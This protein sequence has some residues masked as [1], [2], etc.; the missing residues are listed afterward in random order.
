MR[1]S[2]FM[3]AIAGMS[4]FCNFAAAQDN[5][6]PIRLVVGFAP[7]GALDTVARAVADRLRITLKQPVIVDNKPG[8]SQRLALSEVKRAKP[9]G[10]TL[11]LANS[12]PFIIFPHVYTKLEF[13]P[14]KDFTPVAG[15]ANLPLCIAVGP[16]VPEGNLK[17]V[18]NWAKAHPKEASFATSGAGQMGHF[19]GLMLGSSSGTPFTHVAYKGGVPALQ[20]LIGGQLPMMIDT[21]LEPMEMAKVARVK[22]IATSGEKRLEVLPAVPTIRESGFNLSA[23][24][25][26]GIYG[27]AGIPKDKLQRLNAGLREALASPELKSRIQQLA[28]TPTHLPP[29]ELARWLAEGRAMWEAPIKASGFKAD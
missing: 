28:M 27:P 18:I 21:C 23:E 2:M 5:N 13:D 9:D 29:E 12:S 17:D 10:L 24:H 11:I 1:R 16:K 8:A 22:I 25:M 26:V 6:T 15:I 3:A 19:M 14:V 4:L 7:G 20:D